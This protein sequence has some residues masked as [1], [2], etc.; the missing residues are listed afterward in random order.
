[1]IFQLPQFAAQRHD[2][3]RTVNHAKKIVN[4]VDMVSPLLFIITT[5]HS[6]HAQL[7]SKINIRVKLVGLETWNNGDLISTSSS[8]GTLLTNFENYRPSLL[9]R[10]PNHDTAMLLTL[11]YCTVRYSI[12]QLNVVLLYFYSGIRL[13]RQV[14]GVARLGALC[15]RHSACVA[16][17][18]GLSQAAL[19]AVAAHELG[20]LFGMEHDDGS[21]LDLIT[22]KR[23]HI[24]V[25]PRALQM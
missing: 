18:L 3:Q 15:T 6:L 24:L 19:G 4:L 11:V 8:A 9:S 7:F 25:L 14:A 20:H 5:V 2:V 16:Q 21:K 1:M 23:W 22:D 13:S 17:S 10:F 12:V